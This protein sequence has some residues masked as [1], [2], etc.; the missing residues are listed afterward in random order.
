MS[1][2]MFPV[3][4]DIRNRA[5]I[6]SMEEYNRLYRLS[7]DNP[8]WFWGEQAKTLTWFHPWTSV[9][10]ADYEEADFAWFSGGRL[11][12][13]FNCVDRHLP[14]LAERTAIIWAQDEPGVYTHIS[15]RELKHNVCRVANVLLHHGVKKG[16]RVC[17][18]MTMIPE[19]VYT[20]LACA[21]IGAVHSVVFG[22][23]SSESLRDRIVDAHCKVVVT[24]N[25]GLRGGRKVPLKR[26]VDRAVEGMS[27]V[28]T[29][30]VA[31]R[32]DSEVDMEPGRD[33]WLDEECSKQRSTCTHEWMGSEDPLFVLYTSGS[34]GKPKG[35]L[36]TTGGFLTYAAYTHKLVFDYHPGDIFFCAADIGWVTG[37]SYIVY[38]P[39]ANG[40]TS[41]IF[42]STPLYPDAGRYWRIVDDLGVNILYTAP[43]A[44]RALAQAGDEWIK[45]YS[46]KSLRI[47]GTVGEPINP[48][49][50]RW[51]HDV[52]GEGRCTV[53]DT[54][55]QTETGG[56]LITPLPG[57]T[58]TKPG[59]ATLPFFGVKP[60][61][62]DPATGA[63]ME[64]NDVSGA[65]CLGTPWP[66]Q[67]RTV[68]GDHKR[69]RETY[70]TQY[71]GYYF[72]G[73]GARR[74]EDGYYWITGRIDDVINVSG[75]RLGTAEVES[76][77]VA[78]EA[79]AE[80]AVVGYPHLLKGQGIYCYVLLNSGFGK[81]D[82]E[83]L[84]GALKEQVRQAIGAFA[85]PDVIHIAAGLPK[86]RS[87]KIMRRILR[88]I[89]ASEYE[90]LGDV[91]TLAEPDVVNSL[92]EEHRAT[93]G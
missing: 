62:V 26:T 77:L 68:F 39:L 58:P 76:A 17:L 1:E 60:V 51:Y 56:I 47:L 44:L 34:T 72:T 74:D 67:A 66:G 71:P 36:H 53:V 73:D 12:A 63:V 46:R 27:F 48:E 28:E 35:L 87:G 37:H 30:L 25:E 23:F 22:G 65:L 7:M 29:V 45:R 3:K 80:A 40:A 75:H 20:M 43:T 93:Q 91:S 54:W 85:A 78:H 82:P 14:A 31:R 86:T 88:K 19:L 41:V 9:L 79:V 6:Q 42:E 64:G 21:R 52:I 89:A 5:Y 15:Y 81:E 49:V 61:I 16:D 69:F 33:Y 90:G 55:W 50:W 83:Q 11:N 38:G 24:A 92:I 13:C 2:A 59:S 4:D 10:D 57:V 70:F 32:T 18:Y 8:E 84:I